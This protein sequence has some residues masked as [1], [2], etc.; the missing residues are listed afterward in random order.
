MTVGEES[1]V[2][3][4]QGQR[5]AF[6]TGGS[7]GIGAAITR[8]LAA[9]GVAVAFTYLSRTAEADQ[10]AQDLVRDGGAVLALR[11]DVSDPAELCAAMDETVARLGG[12]TFW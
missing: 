3:G 6:V 12:S 4:N 5:V 10:L 2:S 11:A 8:A 9:D 7:R 1:A